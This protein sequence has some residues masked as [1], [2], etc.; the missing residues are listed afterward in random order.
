VQGDVRDRDLLARL[1][2]GTDVV[3]HLAAQSNVLGAISDPDYSFTTNVVG[4]YEVLRAARVSGVR[5]VIFASSREVYGEP[6]R[7]PVPETAPLRPKNAYGASKVA[8]EMYC[9]A[10][11]EQG[12]DVGILRFSN[13]YGARDRDR[14]IPLFI[15][16][17]LAGRRLVV[18]GQDKTLDFVWIDRAI[19]AL[20]RAG[21][22]PSLH[23]CPINIGSGVG[24][25]LLD[26][27][28]R[29]QSLVPQ[30]GGIDVVTN[31][32]AE[33]DC[34]VAD[35]SC[36]KSVYGLE[37]AVDPLDHLPE[38][39]AGARPVMPRPHVE[40]SSTDEAGGTASFQFHSSEHP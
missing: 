4:T 24:V 33:V 2:E 20:L 3:Y 8:A 23:P 5:R 38:L 29:V 32:Q 17:A 19:E 22:A 31:R 12:L 28:E 25:L 40:S 1:T 11:A 26:L 15:Q 18:Y 30:S 21:T 6:E 16:N 10:F 13:V 14:V 34:F 39:V 9:H 37:Q 36:A 7:T 27:A 35:V